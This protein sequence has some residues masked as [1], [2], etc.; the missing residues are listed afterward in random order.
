MERLE[1]QTPPRFYGR[2]RRPALVAAV[3]EV[4]RQRNSHD[5]KHNSGDREPDAGEREQRRPGRAG[6]LG[7][8]GEV[9]RRPFGSRAGI[10][11]GLLVPR[12]IGDDATLIEP[13]S[14]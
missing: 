1:S 10:A 8:R 11:R 3:E 9:V 2:L 6:A 5:D 13:A 7:L 4:E 12:T 14:R